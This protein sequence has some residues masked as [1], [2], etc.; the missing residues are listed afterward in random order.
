MERA[1]AALDSW[2]SFHTTATL[3]EQAK[4]WAEFG[5][6]AKVQMQLIFGLNRQE[7]SVASSREKKIHAD[8]IL[9]SY[10]KKKGKEECEIIER[11]RALHICFIKLYTPKR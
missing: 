6:F 11:E 7:T 4:V 3:S 9:L 2:V 5:C 8:S 10:H 1:G